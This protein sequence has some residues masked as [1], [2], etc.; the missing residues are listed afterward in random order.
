MFRQLITRFIHQVL[1]RPWL[2]IF[3]AVL[4]LLVTGY[5]A[6]NLT[7]RG[8]YRIYFSEEN[9]QLNAHEAMQK[10]FSK[11]DNVVFVLE[12]LDGQV[13]TTK[14]LQFI[15]ELTEAA[16]LLP[17][18]RRVDSL[19]NFQ[20]SAAQGDELNI[21]NL[22]TDPT[23][24]TP[25]GLQRIREIALNEPL[26][27]NRIVSGKA[28]VT[29]VVATLQVPD[30][31]GDKEFPVIAAEARKLADKLTAEN[32][33]IKV[34]LA[35]IAEM[36]RSFKDAAI[37]DMKTLFPLMY[38][39]MVLMLFFTLR[40][41]TGVLATLLV[42]FFAVLSSLGIAG[43]FGMYISGPSSS[44]A[45]IIL[46]LVIANCVHILNCFQQEMGTTVKPQVALQTSLSINFLPILVAGLTTAIG[47]LSLNFSD[48]PPYRH[49]GN[50][51]AIGVAMTL[52]YSYTLFAAILRLAPAKHRP[53]TK[54]GQVLL[55]KWA[56]FVLGT[57][58]R[59]LP[60]LGLLTVVVLLFVPKNTLNDTFPHYFDK[61]V[62]FR[63]AADFM[64][65]RLSGMTPI[66]I[67]VDTGKA[68][69]IYDPLF[70]ADVARFSQWL[71]A[72][73]EVSNVNSV[74]S[75]LKRL[76]KN[77]HGDDSTM[78]RLP[79][80]A[81]LIAQYLLMYEMSLPMGLSLNDQ[82]SVDKSA[83]QISVNM[84]NISSLEIL[85]L[86]DEMNLW[87]AKNGRSYQVT[88]SGPPLMFSH[89]GQRNIQSM[90]LGSACA[91]V[92]IS[93]LLG[94]IF[95]SSRYGL[96]SLAPNL[97]PAAI[98]FGFWGIFVGQVGVALSV[99]VGMTLGIVVDDT[100]HFLNKYRYAR[101]QLRMSA[102]NAVRHAMVNVG[103]AL[104]VTS[105]VL[106][107]GF[108]VLAT[109]SFKQN[110]DMALLSSVTIAIALVADLL[111]LP[112][113]LLTFDKSEKVT[114]EEFFHERKSEEFV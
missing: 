63:E 16:W 85:A 5:G 11:N 45:T 78:Y 57:G 44:S 111:L 50:I 89:I 108:L 113:L 10:T 51:V 82:V 41:L 107:S 37:G 36:N 40:S 86:E 42:A 67:A 39:V 88:Y 48:V 76:N 1:N 65:E 112:N 43:W 62:P 79:E 32:Q 94:F 95:R 104:I 26:L 55:A 105:V 8:D 102:E 46:T 74:T 14:T 27:V 34:R 99:V 100:I 24:L 20:H 69:G 17:H 101:E 68:N 23:G 103:R 80:S 84:R 87:F 109:S 56:D 35:G 33:G 106:C 110:A 75:V 53:E 93:V 6:K 3:I 81:D 96:I 15:D 114:E 30:A 58:R 38:L 90:L 60:L 29:V 2:L 7:V 52:F 18:V 54:A 98:A 21:E 61:S 91:L 28:D 83:L 73:P 64:E 49:L 92:L 22:V 77:M 47:F 66:H 4:S 72:R 97:L 59:M 19:T 70:M 31:S 13:F 12:P 9:P 25:E 71:E